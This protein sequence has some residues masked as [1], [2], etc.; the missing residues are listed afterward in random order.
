MKLHK[1]TVGA[2]SIALFSGML[3]SVPVS[4]YGSG[5]TWTG[6]AG[7][8]KFETPGNWLQNAVPTNGSRIEFIC[9]EGGSVNIT[10]NSGVKVTEVVT[11]G[12]AGVNSC[13]SYVID[14]LGF[15]GSAG[16]SNY[17]SDKQMRT[18][19]VMIK[20]ASGLTDNLTITD[21]STVNL[22]ISQPLAIKKLNISKTNCNMSSANVRADDAVV[23]TGSNIA[24]ENHKKL[25]VQAGGS[26][27]IN[28][29]ISSSLTFEAGSQLV[30][31]SYEFCIGG[32][33]GSAGARTYYVSGDTIING[34]V[35]YNLLEG[36]TI[37]FTGKVTGSGKFVPA[38]E[39]KGN[40]VIEPS[41]GKEPAKNVI[42]LDDEK[43]E[44][45]EVYPNQ[46]V[47][48]NGKRTHVYV[49]NGGELMG[50]A[51]VDSLSVN[52]IVA[53]GNSPGKITV[54]NDFSL[55]DTGVYAAEILDK[56]HYDQIVAGT[57]VSLAGSL[58]LSYLP[59]GK[60]A[61]G[62]VFT[63]ID[64]K[65]THAVTGTFKAL[66]EGAEIKVNS[67]VFKI[68]YVGGDGNDV[69]LIA[70]NDSVGPKAP[71][72]GAEKVFISPVA[73]VVTGIAAIALFAATLKRKSGA[74]Q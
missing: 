34:D 69:T 61:K 55:Y 23:G 39:N 40:V 42:R 18:P 25:T 20:S 68:S 60:I 44:S 41:N 15:D 22:D 51:A 13:Q 64:N 1:I 70:Q 58:Q 72:T 67:A 47:V 30:E 48:L 11:T 71:N 52:G 19:L 53:P 45:L 10:N 36:V 24:A 17:S 49:R 32:G 37:K 62:D 66:P 54:Q 43:N 27:G 33:S 7:D 31:H 5:F 65:S 14:Q 56:D 2:V 29:N 8:N 12:T 3:A 74:R 6:A 35:S 4:A 21:N 28:K 46:I 16:F 38:S 63:I 73:A 9:K 57:S 59:G 50:N 26:V